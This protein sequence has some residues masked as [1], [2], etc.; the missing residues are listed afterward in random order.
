MSTGIR[1]AGEF[2]WFNMLTPDPSK[3][4]TF[5]GSLLGW[6]Y[7]DTGIGHTIQVEGHSIGALFD[8]ADPNTPQ[9]TPPLIGVMVKV[10]SADA[11][12][13]KVRALGGKARS[14]FNIGGAG[15]MSVCHDPNGVEFDL[16]EPKKLLGTDVD[17]NEIG[18]PTWFETMTTDVDRATRF[19]V[20][21]FGWKAGTATTGY[22]LLNH[23]R[24]PVAGVKQCAPG[25]LL[26]HWG[27][28]FAVKDAERTARD[29]IKLGATVFAPV[30][31]VNGTRFGGVRSPQGVH[32][33][34]IQRESGPQLGRI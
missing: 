25:G 21:L 14:A 22:R 16:W 6:A 24:G 28:Y 29:A 26:P 4:R 5:F 12:C 9:G 3:T 11:A 17:S 7:V 10:E 15:R 1:K 30:M 8:L 27:T 34:V 31:A 23:A 32:F 18:A 33:Y 13:E 20:D 2:C 19:Y